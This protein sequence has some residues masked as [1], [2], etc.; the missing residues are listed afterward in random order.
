MVVAIGGARYTHST[1]RAWQLEHFGREPSHCGRDV[2]TLRRE[3]RNNPGWLPLSVSLH[4][5]GI[6]SHSGSGSGS[7]LL[8]L[9]FLLLHAPHATGILRRFCGLGRGS[10][11]DPPGDPQESS[12]A[13]TVLSLSGRETRIEPAIVC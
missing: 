13:P 7:V 8:T 6:E 12:S 5:P 4:N 9:D 1:S 2:S 11:G 10:A 3:L